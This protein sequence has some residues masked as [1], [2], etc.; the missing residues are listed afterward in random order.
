MAR[1]AGAYTLRGS[2]NQRIVALTDLGAARY[3]APDAPPRAAMQVDVEGDRLYCIGI[4]RPGDMD[5]MAE[6]LAAAGI[7]FG[8][9][10]WR[11]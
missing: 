1:R 10:T 9:L 11:P 5:R 8:G 3:G 4:P 7:A 2:A 6:R